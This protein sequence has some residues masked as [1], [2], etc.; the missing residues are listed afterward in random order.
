MPLNIIPLESIED[1]RLSPY[2]NLRERTLRG[3]SLFIAEGCLVT[4][5]L[6][7]SRFEV[8]S[9]LIS[10]DATDFEPTFAAKLGKIP[11]YTV[12]EKRLLSQIAG[13]P[14][15]QGMLAIGKRAPLPDF[16]EAVRDWHEETGIWIVL[17]DAT[18]PDNLGLV[19][20]SAAALGA[21]GVVLGERCCDPFSRRALRVSMGGVLQVPVIRSLNLLAEIESLRGT[22]GLRFYATVLDPE[23]ISLCTFRKRPKQMA[24]LFGNE[25]NGLAPEYADLCDAK[26]TIPM[27]PNVDSLNLGVSVG[28]FLYELRQA[29]RQ[30]D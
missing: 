20:R 10:A 4:E 12:P 28:V 29:N 26:L 25:Y 8:E 24:L 22:G 21:A 19:F 2:N 30:A 11:I 13:F 1:P 15:H 5:R 18:N 27:A 6:L 23:A 9:L 14:F 17:P 3:E 16:S 7:D